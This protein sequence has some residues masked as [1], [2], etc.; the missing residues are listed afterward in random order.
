MMMIGL[1][2]GM[3]GIDPVHGEERFTFG[4][5]RLTDG[6]SFITVAMGLFA[7]SEAAGQPRKACRGRRI[8]FKHP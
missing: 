6:I 7:V 4:L 5:L 2:L 8:F 1:L 3:V